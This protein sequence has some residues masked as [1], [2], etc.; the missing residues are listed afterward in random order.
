MLNL[1]KSIIEDY[2]EKKSPRLSKVI[3]AMERVE[4]WTVDESQ[5]ITGMLDKMS[6]RLDKAQSDSIE[7][8]AQ[9]VLFI[10]AYMSSG[11]S[12][13][14]MQWFDEKFDDDLSNNIVNFAKL[15]QDDPVNR[16]LL[17]R[18]QTIKSLTLMQSV[19]SPQRTKKILKLL[20]EEGLE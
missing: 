18:L 3:K 10:M 12:I 19:F 8:N 4:F 20:E 14:T 15:N 13:R 1:R 17:D 9:R 5:E 11:R 16:L 2:W 6:S 7:D